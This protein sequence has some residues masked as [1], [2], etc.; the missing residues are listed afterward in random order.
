MGFSLGACA[1]DVSGYGKV[2]PAALKKRSRIVCTIGPSCWSVEGLGM[3]LDEGMNVARLNFSHGDHETHART[4][5]RLKEALA[6]RPG[7]QCA[8]MLDTKGP[9]IRT[10]F[11]GD[12]FE[13]LVLRAG[14]ELV[15]TTD[16]DHKSDGTKLACTYAKLP[17]SVR[18]GNQILIAD[19]SLV[20]EVKAI[21]SETEVRCIV[22]NDA[23][24]GERKNMNLPGV[25][26]ELPVLQP[27]DVADLQ[28]FGVPR[29]V[30]MVA[31]SFVQSAGDVQVVREILDA[32]GGQGIKIISKI[33]NQE[34]LEN[35]DEILAA[36]DGVMVARGDLGMEI[37][38]EHVFSAQKMMIAKCTAVGKPVIVAT[39]MLESMVSNPRPTRAECSDVAN[40]VL[41]G[42]DAVMLSGETAGGKFPREAVA[43]MARICCQAEKSY[44]FEKAYLQELAYEKAKTLSLVEATA[45]AAVQA[46]R[47]SAAKVIIIFAHTGATSMLFAK[48]KCPLPLVVVTCHP[49]VARY[50]TALVAGAKVLL[51]PDAKRYG[52]DHNTG[53]D[54]PR[55]VVEA[56]KFAGVLGFITDPTDVVCAVTAYRLAAVKNIAMRF[57]TAGSIAP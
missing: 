6:L 51:M 22:L 38:P 13:K 14:Q 1:M 52:Y 54:E 33:E 42:A 50:A 47:T 25:K 26:V 5:G 3:L 8:V 57:F 19:G 43:I 40:A 4:I 20:L 12:S 56:I 53:D 39:Q 31:V 45:A 37:P 11:F 49:R 46:A 18:P 29:D 9:E 27:K 21:E 10:G 23:S 7:L 32:A 28:Q 24:I 34:G 17:Q 16:Y 55:M 2:S 44:D 48:Y 35:F 36:N 15:L 30:D 41:D